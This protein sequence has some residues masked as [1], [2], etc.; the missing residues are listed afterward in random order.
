MTPVFDDGTVGSFSFRAWGDLMAAIW[1][2]EENTNKY[3]YMDFYMGC[4]VDTA[5]LIDRNKSEVDKD[6]KEENQADGGGDIRT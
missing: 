2:T 4:L 6:A 5:R 3:S 1:N